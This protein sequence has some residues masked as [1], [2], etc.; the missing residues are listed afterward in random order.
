MMS[1]TSDHA[2]FPGHAFVSLMH[3]GVH[4]RRPPVVSVPGARPRL[5]REN[6][7][8]VLLVPS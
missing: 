8:E 7:P 4:R 5:P 2:Q 1:K 6:H 3:M